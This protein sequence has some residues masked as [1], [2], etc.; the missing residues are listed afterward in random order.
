MT[1]EE[2][3]EYLRIDED[4]T[5]NDDVIQSSLET[6]Q[7]LCLELARCEE[8]DAEENPVVF[9]EAILYAAAFLYEHREEA[10][11]YGL[12]KRLRWHLF[13][14]R[15]SSFRKGGDAKEDRA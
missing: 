5:S 15:R 1:L 3:R 11:Y 7:A 4:D 10:D 6:A 12:L 2:A 8:A 14:V 9:H 13:G